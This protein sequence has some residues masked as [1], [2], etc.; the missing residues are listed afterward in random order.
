MPD[1]HRLLGTLVQAIAAFRSTPGRRGR[2]VQL[3]GAGEV[4]VA[5]DLH[6]NV[7][8]F[9]LLLEKAQL[10]KHPERHLVLQELV[11]GPFCYPAGGDKS[12]QLVGPSGVES[13]AVSS[14]GTPNRSTVMAR[15]W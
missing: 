15:S 6:G 9:R 12:H 2:L 5:G 14:H 7:E 8:N 1:P 4:L 3:E 11:H 13:K 10:G